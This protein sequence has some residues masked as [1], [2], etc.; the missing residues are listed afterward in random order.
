MRSR[1]RLPASRSKQGLDEVLLA[2]DGSKHPTRDLEGWTTQP[3][4]IETCLARDS[5]FGRRHPEQDPA[6]ATRRCVISRMGIVPQ[7]RFIGTTRR[8]RQARRCHQGDL[9]RSSSRLARPCF[10][11]YSAAGSRRGQR[12]RAADPVV[13][14]DTASMASWLQ[15][16]CVARGSHCHQWIDEEYSFGDIGEFRPGPGLTTLATR[17]LSTH[18]IVFT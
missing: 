13:Q 16:R 4:Q 10:A 7:A 17:N 18:A 9:S 5:G 1:K 3:F 2:D 6:V 15:P 14:R 12:P 11:G 8:W